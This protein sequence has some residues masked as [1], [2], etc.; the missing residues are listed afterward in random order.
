MAQYCVLEN[1]RTA[2][3][4]LEREIIGACRNSIMEGIRRLQ[5]I[6][7]LEEWEKYRID[8]DRVFRE[9]LKGIENRDA[10]RPKLVSE[11]DKGE[12]RVENVLFCSLPGWEVN[13]SVY[14]PKGKG[15]FPAVVCPTG[16]SSKFMENYTRSAQTFARN[17]YIAVSFCPPGCSGE[18]QRLNE[19]FDNGI[20]EWLV[21]IWCQ[22]HFVADAL[23]CVDYLQQRED[24]DSSHGYAMTGVSGGGLTTFFCAA[25]DDR[26]TFAAPVCCVSD[27]E[28][29]SFRDLYTSCPEQHGPGYI[30]NGLDTA[31]LLSLIAPKPLVVVG[32]KLDEVFHYPVT[33]DVFAVVKKIYSLYGCP[34]RAELFLQEDSG[35][36]Y[37][38]VMANRVLESMN[39]I[40]KNGAA[41]LP[42]TE[43]DMIP[44]KKE[45]LACY[46]LGT[47]NMFT[48]AQ[49]AGR[50]LQRERPQ[51]SGEALQEEVKRLLHWDGICQDFDRAEETD[52]S[53][54]PVRWHHIFQDVI[55]H[56]NGDKVIPGV[57]AHREGAKNRPALLY[58]D[59]NG[60][61]NDFAWDG[62]LGK[63]SGVLETTDE[64]EARCVFA[65]DV[66]GLGELEMQYT[67]YDTSFWNHIERILTYL[68][69]AQG[70]PLIA[71]QVR[72]A[73]VAL[74]YLK[75]RKEADGSRLILA[76]RGL[77]AN[78]A[79][80][81]GYLAGDE[82]EKV[83]AIEPLAAYQCLTE[84]FPNRWMPTPLIYDVLNHFDLPDVVADLGEK[85][86]C[87]HPCDEMR[88]PMQEAQ[89]LTYYGHALR[90]GAKVYVDGDVDEIFCKSC[91]PDI[92]E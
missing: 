71:Y 13:A 79:L 41:P 21:G 62:P 23:A 66:S 9:A 80:L 43:A 5:S 78:I 58:L 86:V 82:V 61:W 70:R 49:E 47:V 84:A 1:G 81:A 7:S 50:R 34:E 3:Q 20:I 59:E 73:L 48:I 6:A 27:Q 24:V 69:V 30:G 42:L 22:V 55:L 54:L 65:A 89:M 46:P 4:Q 76:G 63:I 77:G 25:C 19:H 16:H 91:R 74:H 51:L 85:A 28:N 88:R 45:E 52:E 38:V 12:F 18:L 29:L 87:I 67:T 8:V 75:Q 44:L 2:A 31:H 60:K 37:T 10:I 39:K 68:S 14:I 15:P 11:V 92:I 40:F 33:E 83:I 64:A 32:G 56:H 26:I 72:D 17:G 36:A 53:T 57:F 90:Q 35:H